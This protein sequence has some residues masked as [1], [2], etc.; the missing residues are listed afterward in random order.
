MLIF[1]LTFRLISFILGLLCLIF[2]FN[3]CFSLTFGFF[4]LCLCGALCQFVFSLSDFS[5]SFMK[6]FIISSDEFRPRL[7]CYFF[8]SVLSFFHLFQLF[9]F[10]LTHCA[11]RG[12][13]QA[14]TRGSLDFGQDWL[15]HKVSL[16]T[17][18]RAS[19]LARV[20]QWLPCQ[21]SGGGGG[22]GG[23]I[24]WL[25]DF[26][27]S[28]SNGLHDPLG[29]KAR[30]CHSETQFLAPHSFTPLQISPPRPFCCCAIFR[31]ACNCVVAVGSPAHKQLNCR[32]ISPNIINLEVFSPPY[33]PS[34]HSS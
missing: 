5:F 1:Y 9:S 8:F 22:G 25:A 13:R 11:G 7:A 23:Y 32:W 27:P 30:H 20:Y 3:F 14:R 2:C 26:L 33:C 31:A 6:L 28:S 18:A 17:R 21:Y 29:V 10:V 16:L 12:Q 4:Q 34:I 19:V 24:N 15:W